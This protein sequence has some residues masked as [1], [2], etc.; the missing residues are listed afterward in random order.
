MRYY[1]TIDDQTIE[2]NLGADGI[3]VDGQHVEAELATAPG[4]P[5]RRLAFLGRSHAVHVAGAEGKGN[6]DFHLDG[7]RYTAQVVDERAHA[8]RQMTGESTQQV[9]PKP[10]KAPMP[11]MV[12]R[13]Q[14]AVG[15][16]VAVGQGVVIIEAM[17]MENELKAAAPGVVKRIFANQGEAVEKGMVLVEFE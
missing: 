16:H 2:V 15:D 9:G 13:V 4:S 8:I 12:V 5:V 7:E 10:V 14:V 6:W 3:T 1:V 11:G 17:K